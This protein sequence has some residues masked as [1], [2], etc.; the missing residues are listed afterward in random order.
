MKQFVIS[1]ADRKSSPIWL[2]AA[3]LA[4]TL[5]ARPALAGETKTVD[6]QICNATA[7]YFLEL[8]DYPDAIRVHRKILD[9]D[10][11]NALA[12]YHLGFAYGMVGERTAEKR[13]YL[14]AIELGLSQWDLLLNLGLAY[15]E[16][17][18]QAEALRALQGAATVAPDRP[19]VHFNLALAYEGAGMLAA[20]LQEI[21]TSL[22]LD[23]NQPDARN[24][25]GVIYAEL[26]DYQRAEREWTDLVRTA[27]DYAPAQAN[28]DLLHNA[29]SSRPNATDSGLASLSEVGVPRIPW[30]SR[31]K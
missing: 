15:L 6:D 14:R 19:E 1:N 26:G 28:L 9:H 31:N 11:N 21:S 18:E 27:P 25:L 12:H 10:P 2:P 24:T 3:L 30:T 8:E 22:R 16:D 20:A 7:D 13:E 23:P 17:G 4:L 29:K 5:S